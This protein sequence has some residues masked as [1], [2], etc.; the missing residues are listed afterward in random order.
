MA[1]SPSCTHKDFCY[2]HDHKITLRLEF[3]W[4]DAPDA[5]PMGMVVYFYPDNPDEGIPYQFNFSNTTGGEIAVEPG[6]YHL[7]TYNNDTEFSLSYATNAFHTHQIFTREGSL[8]EPMAMTRA[9]RNRNE[10]IPRPEGTDSQRVVVCP[11][12]IWGCTAIDI[13]VTEQGVRYICIP[14][15][16]KDQWIDLTP[17]ETEHVITLYP[18]DL[19]CHYSFEVRNVSGLNNVQNLCG[20]LT[21]MSPIL[22]LHDEELDKECITLPVE[23]QKV[24][25]TTIEGSFLTFGHHAD[26]S[27]PHLFAL[28]LQMNDGTLQY[29]CN[30]DNF[31]VTDQIHAAPDRRRVHFIIDGLEIEGGGNPEGG[32]SGWQSSFDDWG[33]IHEDLILK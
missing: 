21:G 17:V 2:H 24:N 14:F 33:E 16:Y 9:S 29:K 15:E 4:R 12:E 22:R 28:Y 32:G 3:D 11:D 8:L 27:D 10:G 23:A 20:A 30:L 26:N 5:D 18:H 1:I 6:K 7:V 13:E 19:L 31:D 25:D